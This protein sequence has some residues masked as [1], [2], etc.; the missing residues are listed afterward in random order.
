M[1]ESQYLPYINIYILKDI[2]ININ[3][4]SSPKLFPQITEIYYYY[5]IDFPAERLHSCLHRVSPLTILKAL[6]NFLL[7]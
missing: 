4:Q 6:F 7:S 5:Y 2:N 3:Y 1:E